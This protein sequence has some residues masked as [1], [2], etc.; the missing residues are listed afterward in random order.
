[1]RSNTIERLT[2][3]LARLNQLVDD[4]DRKVDRI[5]LVTVVREPNTQVAA[6]AY[7]GLRRQVIAATGERTAHLHQLA[8]FSEAVAAGAGPED[9]R[10]LVVEW[11]GQASMATLDDPEVAEA[12]ELVGPP[13]ATGRRVLRPAYVDTLTARVVR[14]GVVERFETQETVAP[15]ADEEPAE[16]IT[17]PGG[18]G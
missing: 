14:Q 11:L 18:E 16:P 2:G 3:E 6:D 13:E 8:Q 9:L 12:F 5:E 1:V 4:M 17:T 7:N 10:A 15:Q